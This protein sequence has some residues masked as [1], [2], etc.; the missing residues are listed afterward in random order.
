ML[1]L[2]TLLLSNLQKANF[3]P[4]P[5]LVPFLNFTYLFKMAIFMVFK[6]QLK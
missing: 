6:T 1:I 4:V 2:V 5:A 3:R